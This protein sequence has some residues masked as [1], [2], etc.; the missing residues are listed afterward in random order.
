MRINCVGKTY[1]YG[2][3]LHTGLYYSSTTIP[4]IEKVANELLQIWRAPGSIILILKVI[5][6]CS[7]TRT[8]KVYFQKRSTT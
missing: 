8:L 1:L 4:L 6:E 5:T 2:I 7:D 3:C